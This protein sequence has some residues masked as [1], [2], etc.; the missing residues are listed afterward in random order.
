MRREGEKPAP[1]AKEVKYKGRKKTLSTVMIFFGI[2][3]VIFALSFV[4]AY[5]LIVNSNDTKVKVNSGLVTENE[6]LK[7]MLTEYEDEIRTLEEEIKGL[8]ANGNVVETTKTPAPPTATNAPAP[9][10]TATPAP[11][12][13][14]IQKTNEPSPTPIVSPTPEPTPAPTPEVAHPTPPPP[15]TIPPSP[16]PDSE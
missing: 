13:R 2:L 1:I 14:P 11:T 5:N 8:K 9:V 12:A 7:A 6:E 15:P 3:V 16:T 10:A 4:V